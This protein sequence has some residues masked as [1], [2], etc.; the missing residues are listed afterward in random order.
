MCLDWLLKIVAVKDR[1]WT[2][3]RVGIALEESKRTWDSSQE[4]DVL[5]REKN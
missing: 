5:L 4:Y 2:L 3:L 1:C